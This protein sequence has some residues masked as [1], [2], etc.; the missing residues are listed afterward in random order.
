MEAEQSVLGALLL[1]NSS[2]GAVSAVLKAED[3]FRRDHQLIYKRI[4]EMLAKGTPCDFVTLSEALRERRELEEVGGVSYIGTLAM[5]TPSAANVA[6][7]ARIVLERS[8]LREV[9]AAGVSIAEFGYRPDGQEVEALLGR[10]TQLLDVLRA[11]VAPQDEKGW[12]QALV[13]TESGSVKGTLANIVTILDQHRMWRDKL[14]LDIRSHQ[15]VKYG[16]PVGEASGTFGDADAVEIAAWLGQ[17]QTFKLSAA[18]TQVREAAFAVAARRPVNPLTEW[19]DTLKWDETER[20]ETFFSKFC[21]STQSDYTAIAA[22]NFF[23]GAVARAR[24]PGCKMDLML[25][26]EGAQ[27]A[28]KTSLLIALAGPEF[29]AEAMESPAQKDFYQSLQGRWIIEIAEMQSFSKAEVAKVKQAITA[30]WDFYRPSYGHYAKNYPRQCVFVGTTNEDDYLRD[31]TGARRFMP[32]KVF[33]ID[34]DQVRA[35][36][37]QLWAEADVRFK[38]GEVYWRLPESAQAE[39]D[40]RYQ[41]DSWTDVVVRWLEGK[42]PNE[43]YADGIAGKIEETNTTQLLHKAIGVETGKHGKTEQQRIGS[44]MRRLGWARVQKRIDGRPLWLYKR[45][46]SEAQPEAG[47]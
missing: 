22:K 25:I 15:I 44:I 10:S 47:T 46:R 28:R 6:S 24:E 14:R 42:M 30:Q 38:R 39:Q 29:Y 20:I 3:F 40:A 13:R 26:L 19:L 43:R 23:L 36:R 35:I 11:R 8:L 33:G 7:W 4:G 17:P 34:I 32:V 12:Q 27:G 41:E 31:A 5:D 37:E 16:V 9:I 45:P 1:D 21:G 2:W 18:T